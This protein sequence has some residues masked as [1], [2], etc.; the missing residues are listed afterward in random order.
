[1]RP[2]I[3][4]TTGE[5]RNKAEPWSPVA[6]G[7]SYTYTDAVILGGGTPVLLPLTADKDV[8]MDLYS[9]L[10]GIL[11]SGGND[12]DSKLYEQ[13]PYRNHEDYSSLR[14]EMEM[15]LMRLALKDDKPMLCICRGMQL[16]NIAL[17]GDLYQDIAT[18][19]PESLD[20]QLSSKEKNMFHKAHDLKVEAGS[21]LADITGVSTIAANTHHHQALKNLG[22]GL[23]ATAWAEDGII[24][25]VENTDQTYCLGLQCHPE[26]LVPDVVPE[27]TSVFTA[28]VT[29]ANT[30]VGGSFK[31]S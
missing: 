21:Y 30:E 12:V 8:V 7:Q 31:V 1:M 22:K 24:E 26:S 16:L 23:K 3:G 14:D 20:H 15:L 28:F 27:W 11:F 13:Q 29:A 2:L 25:A 4:V 9:R 6:Y 17:G 5:I 19:L 18:D 10:D